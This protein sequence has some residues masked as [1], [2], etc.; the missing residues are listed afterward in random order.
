VTEHAVTAL[1]PVREDVFASGAY[2]REYYAE[3]G[4]ENA[5]AGEFLC[6]IAASLARVRS[7]RVL[8]AGCGPTA[9]YWSLFVPGDNQ[10]EGFDLH[11]A[12]IASALQ[13]LEQAKR[14]ETD[15]ALR[16]AAQHALR[17]LRQSEPPAD[18]I[19]KKAGQI[20][21]LTV[22]DLTKPWPC[23][24]DQYDFVQ[25]C[26]AFEC[27]PSWEGFEFALGEA[28]R[29]LRPGGRLAL[30]N[31]SQANQW[32]CN[33]MEFPTLNLTLDGMKQRIEKTGLRM[34]KSRE[35]ESTDIS[36]RDQGYGSIILTAAEKSE[37]APKR[38]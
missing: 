7:L 33:G 27:L 20:R 36:V 19:R 25:S 31:V 2:W 28:C 21:S 29:V 32:H 11:P 16:L 17:L 1:D 8:D 38:S 3:P 34:L 6:E 35:L 5:A 4:H 12:N 22:G 37:S 10:V 30:V 13:Q 15:S 14:G 18:H 9:L 24:S 23:G 26:F